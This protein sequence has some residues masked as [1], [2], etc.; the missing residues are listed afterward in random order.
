[1]SYDTLPDFVR[2]TATEL[3]IPG[4]AVGVWAGGQEIYACH[5]VTSVDNPLPVDQDTLFQLGSV[6]KTYTATAVL[7][8]VASG[9]VELDAPVR[10]YVPELRLADERTA[11]EI[12]VSQ[13]LNHTA[14]LDWGLIVDTGEGDDAL[15]GYVAKM[16]ELTLI[17]APGVRASYSQAGYNLLGR[18]IE[19]VVGMPYEKAIS[20]LVFEPLGLSRSFFARDD[21]MTRRFAVGHNLDEDGT[22]SVARPWRHSRSGNPGG[23]IVASVSDQLR[24]ARFQLGDGRAESGA[25]VLPAEVLHR[26]KEPT[27]ALRASTLGDAIGLGWFL[28][29]VDGVRTVG[30]G[31]SANGQFAEFLTVPERDFAIVAVSNAGPNGIPFNQAVVRWALDHYLGLVDGDPTPVPYDRGRAQELVGRYDIDSMTLAIATDGAGL[32]LEVRIKPEIRTASETELPADYPPADFGLLPGD[33]DEY[34]ITGGGLKGQRGY[35]TRDEHGAVV[36]A[37]LAGRLFNR[38]KAAAG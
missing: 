8:L 17:A 3:G 6:T 9:R 22:L 33:G 34:I 4:V 26:M 25:P 31:G 30:H 5:G 14:G 1:M 19:K 37:D 24:W 18:V 38:V 10:R 2:A 29:D 12:T 28:R 32:T 13:L 23:G 7:H 27:V 16:A 36:G 15:A 20:S 11:A 35:F 21:V